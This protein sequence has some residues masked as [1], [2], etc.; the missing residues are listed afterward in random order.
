MDTLSAMGLCAEVGDCQRFEKPAQLSAYLGLLPAEYTT[1]SKR[2]LGSITK[3]GSS[4]ARRLLVEAAWHYRRPPRVGE[5][6]ERR[7][8]GLPPDVIAVAWRC[9]QRLHDRY[10]VLRLERG[11][12]AGVVTIAAAR[13]LVGFLWEAA[14]LDC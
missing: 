3:A 8:R 2:R 5:T 10:R 4:H 1:D 9:Q 12:P 6:L 14:T 11:K 7:Q 13:E